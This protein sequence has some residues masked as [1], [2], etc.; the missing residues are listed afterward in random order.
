MKAGRLPIFLCAASLALRNA[1][2]QAPTRAQLDASKL[3]AFMLMLGSA[4]EYLRTHKLISTTAASVI[5]L[6]LA[7]GAYRLG[8]ARIE[9]RNDDRR[10]RFRRRKALLTL[11]VLAATGAL[12]IAWAQNLSRTATFLGLIGAGIA[13]ALREP[14]LGIA[15]RLAVLF[16][17]MFIIGDR[18]EIN[19]MKGDVVDIGF[20]Y[21][22][23]MEI[24]NWVHGDQ[25]SGRVIQFSNAQL[26]GNAVFN[27]TRHF[28]YIWDEVTLPITYQSNLAAAAEILK[29]AGL[30]YSSKFLSE[31][32]T[33]LREMQS[34][35][36]ISEVETQPSVY[37]R[38]TSNWL[39]LNLRYVVN[40]KLRRQASS[41]IYQEIFQQ[42]E[43]RN[44]VWIAST[45]QD[46]TIHT[47][48]QQAVHVTT[49]EP[50]DENSA[51]GGHE[52][53]A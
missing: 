5:V 17:K 2:N 21:T 26:F 31:A 30:G 29:N 42:V 50:A 7:W 53:A 36:L 10:E 35:F 18:I 47:P 23:M 14:L 22:R 38:V 40:P 13:I 1:A 27:Y 33:Q 24:G 48:N 12:V 37:I 32:E 41:F 20:F 15:G 16:G 34:Y 8:S 4:A 19:Q 9:H 52:K 49:A 51:P 25:Y 6:L 28:A 44:D 45:T 43:K 39:E 3:A 46:L 11:V